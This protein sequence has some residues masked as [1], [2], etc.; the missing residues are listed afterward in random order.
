MIGTLGL[1]LVTAGHPANAADA[2]SIGDFVG[3]FRGEAQVEAGDRFFIHCAVDAQCRE[4]PSQVILV[5]F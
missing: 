3:H 1:A 2:L 4:A 5:K